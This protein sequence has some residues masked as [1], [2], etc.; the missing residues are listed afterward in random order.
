MIKIIVNSS[1]GEHLKGLL[2]DRFLFVNPEIVFNNKTHK[3]FDVYLN[4]DGNGRISDHMITAYQLLGVKC[5]G[6]NRYDKSVQHLILKSLSPISFNSL[7]LSL[8]QITISF[9]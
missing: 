4:I 5:I 6:S 3:P 8:V 7:Y 9:L 2:D 1:G